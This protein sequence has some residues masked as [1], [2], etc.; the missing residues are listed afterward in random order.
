MECLNDIK[1]QFLRAVKEKNTV[2]YPKI[3]KRIKKLVG[4]AKEITVKRFDAIMNRHEPQLNRT[5]KYLEENELIVKPADKNLGLTIIPKSWYMCEVQKHLDD[6]T[7][8]SMLFGEPNWGQIKQNLSLILM[9]HHK[10][11]DMDRFVAKDHQPANFY[12]IPK[13]HKTPVKTRPILPGHSHYT[14]LVSEYL[15]KKTTNC[16]R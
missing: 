11:Q 9:K 12:V 6:E 4:D 5:L 8:Y 15:A 3:A 1:T 13:L 14:H 10:T 7:T 2:S 16:C